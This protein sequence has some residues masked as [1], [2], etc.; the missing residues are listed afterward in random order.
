MLENSFEFSLPSE[1]V[2]YA[3]KNFCVILDFYV[4]NFPVKIDAQMWRKIRE[5]LEILS[6]L[7]FLHN[8]SQVWTK[9]C[10]LISV[11]KKDALK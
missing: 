5:S 7:L 8:D 2:L 6:L 4:N 11:L 3:L 10:V 1:K 9:T